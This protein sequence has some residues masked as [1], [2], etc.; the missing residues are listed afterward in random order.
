MLNNGFNLKLA[1]PEWNLKFTAMRV[2][3]TIV[4]E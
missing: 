2:N 1:N 3:P 4:C